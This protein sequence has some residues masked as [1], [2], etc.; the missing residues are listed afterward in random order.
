MQEEHLQKVVC[1]AEEYSALRKKAAYLVRISFTRSAA[2][3][4]DVLHKRDES[5]RE[6][7]ELLESPRC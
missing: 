6:L 7:V 3:L 1:A 5:R 2:G 4:G